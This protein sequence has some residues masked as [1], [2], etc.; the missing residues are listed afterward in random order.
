M[1]LLLGSAP[2]PVGLLCVCFPS[3]CSAGGGSPSSSLLHL[4]SHA[5]SPSLFAFTCLRLPLLAP[6]A[7]P[8][9]CLE[10]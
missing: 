7:R 1:V 9:V 3:T 4:R 2:A 10:D 6:G 8:G 5:G